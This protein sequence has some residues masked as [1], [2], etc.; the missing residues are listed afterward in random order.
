MNSLTSAIGFAKQTAKGTPAVHG[1]ATWILAT[2]Q[3]A[4]AQPRIRQLPF[5][6]GGTMLPNGMIKA[7]VSG[8]VASRGI[9]RPSSLG[10]ILLGLIGDVVS[11]ANG[12]YYDHTFEIDTTA[13]ADVPYFTVFRQ[14]D[15]DFGE[16]ISDVKFSSLVMDMQA[17][18][19]VTGEWSAAGIEPALVSSP[20][21][22]TP[23]ADVT[24]PFVSCVGSVL[25]EGGETPLTLPVRA[26]TLT[27]GNAQQ[28]DGNFVVGRYTPIDIDV[29]SRVVT[30]SMVVIVNSE[31]L[32]QKLMY[33]PTAVGVAWTPDIL[34]TSAITTLTFKSAE[35]M[36]SETV[37]YQLTMSAYNMNWVC[38]PISMRG[39]DNILLRV[40]GQVMDAP[41]QDPITLVLSNKTTSY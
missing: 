23:S 24:A 22:W 38:E 26:A 13:P 3:T 27:I 5:E 6:M 9:P 8:L 41:G 15:S 16:T 37:P 28:I 4:G 12:T 29:I 2:D 35:D 7:G 33:D 32:Y 21:G 20:T 11:A 19:Y 36:P 34:S 17:V 18:N 1:S 40:T 10:L 39:A 14:V 31:T 25:L 30:V